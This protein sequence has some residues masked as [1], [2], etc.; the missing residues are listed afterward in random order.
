MQPAASARRR[1]AAIRIRYLVLGL[2]IGGIWAYHADEPP[3]KHAVKLVILLLIFMPTMRL[4]R[5][6]LAK[7]I[8][9]ARPWR[10][11]WP[12]LV[13]GKVTLLVL[14][15]I[16]S[17]VLQHWL[18]TTATGFAVAAG[19]VAVVAVAGPLVHRHLIIAVPRADGGVAG[20][21]VDSGAVGAARKD[22]PSPRRIAVRLGGLALVLGAGFAV[23]Q[24]AVGWLLQNLT[25]AA[26]IA[27][28]VVLIATVAVLGVLTHRRRARTPR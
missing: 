8:R 17:W 19:L 6:M 15:F 27:V 7:R 9:S 14:A 21:P 23:K 12:R 22:R 13:A 18:S 25:T 24:F 3:W 28:A 10:L 2:V 1:R 20:P 5:G 11:S 16:A 26:G 4:V